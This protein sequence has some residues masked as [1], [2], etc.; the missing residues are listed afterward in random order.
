MLNRNMQPEV[1]SVSQ[2]DILPPEYSLLSNGVPLYII[3]TGDQEVVRLDLVF[4]GGR[5]HQ[6]HLLQALFTNRMLREGTVTYTTEQIA[7]KLDYYGAWL[8]LSTSLTHSFITLYSLSR[9]FKET[10]AIL[11]SLV[12]EPVFP[13]AQL[14]TT[15]AVN[16]Q[17]YLINRG[18]VNVVSQKTF[19]QALFGKDHPYGMSAEGEDYDRIE[20]DWLKE[21]YAS[22]YHSGNCS[23]Y[24]SGRITDDIR[25]RTI[26][27]FG[28]EAFG[29]T[30]SVFETPAYR[31]TPAPEKRILAYVPDAV[32]SS[33]KMGD[34]TA[35]RF[36]SDYADLRVLITL[37]GG[38][39]GSRLMSNIREEKGYTYGIS[40]GIASFQDSGVLVIST[41][42]A[43]EY[44]EEVIKEVYNE[45]DKLQNEPVSARELDMVRNYMLGD[46]C[47]T[48]ESLFSLA[49]NW[50]SLHAA[51][52]TPEYF[53]RNI[54]AIH[55]ITPARL[56]QLASTWLCKKNLKEIIAGEKLR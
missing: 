32:Q 36:H 31:M 47:R 5:W 29:K 37:F 52:L 39:F 9:Y 35:G 4:E 30:S 56:Q 28:A 23:V 2:I 13:E 22:C 25:L 18:K 44:V 20:A 40:A 14:Q 6:R 15:V 12:K 49:D 46:M 55:A 43:N 1:R 34:L 42:T 7:R 51:G 26:A 33:M 41:E 54:N 11:E 16:K 10:L 21:F 45:I 27:A 38:Y 53:Q 3:N 50:I 17:H 24:L 19:L 8:E 48:F